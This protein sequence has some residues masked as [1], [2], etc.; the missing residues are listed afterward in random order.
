MS[1][2]RQKAM[3]EAKIF[4]GCDGTRGVVGVV[5]PHHLG[6]L[7]HVGRYGVQFGE[8]AIPLVERHYV[9]LGA[10]EHGSD[11]VDRVGRVGYQGYIAGVQE[12]EGGVADTFFGPD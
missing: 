4:F 1:F 2:S 8:P 11:P 7:S 3:A 6:R 10:G 12:A 9:T 5:Q